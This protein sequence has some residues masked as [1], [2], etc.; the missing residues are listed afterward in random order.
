V[1]SA[2]HSLR[3]PSQQGSACTDF[4]EHASFLGW[5]TMGQGPSIAP[6]AARRHSPVRNYY[7]YP[8]LIG[9]LR[10]E[11]GRG[12]PLGRSRPAAAFTLQRPGQSSPPRDLDVVAKMSL[13]L[14]WVR[15]GARICTRSHLP[16]AKA[17]PGAWRLRM[18]MDSRLLSP[19]RLPT[20]RPAV[21]RD[22]STTHCDR[23]R[24]VFNGGRGALAV[25]YGP[26][27]VTYSY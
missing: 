20:A 10:V 26:K 19:V 12:G 25:R 5:V 18:N 21:S 9:L 17:V 11:S 27:I 15:S 4:A 3:M 24:W 7:P 6:L 16:H 23:R 8:H 14:L 2:F 13:Y 1:S 22:R